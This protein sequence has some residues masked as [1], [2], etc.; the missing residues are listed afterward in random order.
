MGKDE[1]LLKTFIDKYE[2]S[3][4]EPF[5]AGIKEDITSV[6][7]AISSPVSS[8]F[9]E[10]NNNKFKLIKRILF[11]RANLDSLFKKCYLAFRFSL[12]DF[13]SLFFPEKANLS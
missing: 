6:T 10:G 3:L 9:V 7:N 4:V 5:I 8:G 2:F 13:I 1:S 12:Y 11:G